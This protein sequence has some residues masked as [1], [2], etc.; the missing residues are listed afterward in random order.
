MGV[1]EYHKMFVAAVAKGRGVSVKAVRSDFGDGKVFQAKEAVS[2][3]MADRIGTLDETLVRA[4]R[5][6]TSGRTSAEL[7]E[8]ARADRAAA[9]EWNRALAALGEEQERA[10]ETADDEIEIRLRELDL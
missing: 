4:S 2:R 9:Y 5:R 7:V 3:G 10:A 1:D 8:S 6:R